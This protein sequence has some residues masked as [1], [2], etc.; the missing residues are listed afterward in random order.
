MRFSTLPASLARELRLTVRTGHSQAVQTNCRRSLCQ[1]WI[2]D[3]R[4]LVG[5][6]TVLLAAD[7]AGKLEQQNF[8]HDDLLRNCAG[9]NPVNMQELKKILSE[10]VQKLASVSSAD[11]RWLRQMTLGKRGLY[12]A[13]VKLFCSL[14]K[15][16]EL[17]NRIAG[18]TAAEVAARETMRDR[19]MAQHI[20]S[21]GIY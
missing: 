20:Q 4:S 9:A 2:S 3:S 5:Q 8:V 21:C 16:K 12:N 17:E 13:F 1:I 15:A 6:Q 14:R 7:R 10:E 19:I 18:E 11:G